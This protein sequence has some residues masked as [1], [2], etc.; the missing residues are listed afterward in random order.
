MKRPTTWCGVDEKKKSPNG[1]RPTKSSMK[2]LKKKS[3]IWNQ[4][5]PDDDENIKL[6]GKYVWEAAKRVYEFINAHEDLITITTFGE[7]RKVKKEVI[8][9][10]KEAQLVERKRRRTSRK[11]MNDEAIT[12]KQRAKR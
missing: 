8:K 1:A 9:V 3:E 10:I 7:Y 4:E 6:N 12:R 5:D 2:S 11:K